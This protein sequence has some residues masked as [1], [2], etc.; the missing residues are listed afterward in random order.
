M[1][2]P[3]G[4]GSGSVPGLAIEVQGLAYDGIPLFTDLTLELRAGQWTGLLGPSGTGKSALIRIAAGLDVG[5]GAYRARPTDGAPLQ[6]SVALM[7]QRDA[8]LPWLTVL[9]NACLDDRTGDEPVAAR[10]ERAAAL[11]TEA[12]LAEYLDAAPVTLSG[13]MRQ[14]VVLVRAL[15]DN[16]PIV[17]LDEPFAAMDAASRRQ[18]QDLAFR[19]L[20]GRTILSVTHDPMEALR[21]CQRIVLA[22]GRPTRLRDV[23]VPDTPSPRPP[24]NPAVL[25]SY[26]AL[27]SFLLQA[28]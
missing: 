10:K 23:P 21:L 4:T 6:A 7:A 28:G 22:E 26:Q 27:L 1:S 24:D 18:M 19:E 9:D 16:R 2:S 12:G 3:A 15:L 20:A 17:L 8:L 5:K 13:G 14:R 11:L 25:A